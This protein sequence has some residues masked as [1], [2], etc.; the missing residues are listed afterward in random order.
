MDLEENQ[1]NAVGG[2]GTQVALF[3]GQGLALSSF[4]TPRLALN[5]ESNWPRL[6]SAGVSGVCH[7]PAH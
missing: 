4:R 6:P 3:G 7:S 5:A 1:Q 2:D